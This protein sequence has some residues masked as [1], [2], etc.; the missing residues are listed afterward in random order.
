MLQTKLLS[1]NASVEA[2]ELNQL[3]HALNGFLKGSNDIEPEHTSGRRTS[4]EQ[5]YNEA[6]FAPV[7]HTD[8]HDAFAEGGPPARPVPSNSDTGN[9]QAWA[10]L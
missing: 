2:E 5:S 8:N 10:R 7:E 4:A 1:F 3:V 9:K 6:K